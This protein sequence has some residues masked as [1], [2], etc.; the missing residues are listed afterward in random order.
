MI[1]IARTAYMKQCLDQYW[2]YVLIDI[3]TKLKVPTECC[4]DHQCSLL[5]LNLI[6]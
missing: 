3:G 6:L 2:C 5:Y 4:A 1:K